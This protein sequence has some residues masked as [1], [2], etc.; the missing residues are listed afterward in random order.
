MKR[1]VLTLVASIAMMVGMLAGP[2]MAGEVTG[3]G[4]STPIRDHVA[5]SICSFSGLDDPDPDFFERTQSYGQAVRLGF[6]SFAPSP[7]VA[8]NPNSSFEE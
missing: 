4:K 5:A 6:K 1:R 3:N 7:G 2:A 8:C